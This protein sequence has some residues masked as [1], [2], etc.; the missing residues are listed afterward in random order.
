MVKSGGVHAIQRMIEPTWMTSSCSSL[1]GLCAKIVLF[2]LEWPK[3][4]R[5][6]EPVY[7]MPWLTFSNVHKEPMILDA[8]V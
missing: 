5:V 2:A 4:L 7:G 1:E 8:T 6:I 3:K